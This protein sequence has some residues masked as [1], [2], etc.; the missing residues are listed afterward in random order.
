MRTERNESG[1][2]RKRKRRLGISLLIYQ[3][4]V[5]TVFVDNFVFVFCFFRQ[6][7]AK[8]PRQEM[9]GQLSLQSS[10]ASHCGRIEFYKFPFCR[11]FLRNIQDVSAPPD[12]GWTR[13]DVPK[14]APNQE[15][16]DANPCNCLWPLRW[17]QEGCKMLP[18]WPKSVLQIK[19]SWREILFAF[20]FTQRSIFCLRVKFLKKDSLPPIRACT[21]G[22]A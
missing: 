12:S 21:H 6:P 17:P 15:L 1:N 2:A 5:K 7:L 16:V 20:F 22:P 18:R 11:Y 9:P 10:F 13:P 14:N 19:S 8:H 3:W 4:V